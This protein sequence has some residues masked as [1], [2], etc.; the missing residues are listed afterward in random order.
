M[1]NSFAWSDT[2]IFE[3][4]VD[5]RINKLSKEIKK[6][7]NL[8]ITE[9]LRWSIQ[10]PLTEKEKTKGISNSIGVYKIIYIPTGEVMDIGNGNISNR[11]QRHVSVFKNGGNPL[12]HKTG[13]SSASTPAY[14][15]YK[16]DP[17][18]SNWGFQWS[19]LK[20]K[21]LAEEVET[22]LIRSLEPKFNS[23]HMAGK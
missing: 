19:D 4:S 11:K 2:H 18:L 5:S 16:H 12:V 8:K 17:N 3:Y 15:M 14:Y 7:Q 20:S 10:I 6:L 9:S 21:E 13:S 22:Q 1:N 23:Q